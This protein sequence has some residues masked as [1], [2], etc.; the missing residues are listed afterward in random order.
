[1]NSFCIYLHD[2][3]SAVEFERKILWL[4]SR[5]N[6]ISHSD[7][8]DIVYQGKSIKNSCHITVDDGWRSTYE[9]VMPIMKK[10]N[11]PFSMFVSP[12]IINE[13]INYWYYNLKLC[14][15]NSLYDELIKRKY[16]TRDVVKFPLDL[17]LK[18]IKIDNI[19]ALISD[20]L[21]NNNIKPERGF[22]N[23]KE[24]VEMSQSSLIEI[25]AHTLTHPILSMESD[26]RSEYEIIESISLLENSIEKSVYSFAY[27][28]GLSRLDFS[29]REKQFLKKTKIKLAYSV[30]PGFVTNNS[31]PFSIPRI[32]NLKRLAFGSLG[33]LLPSLSSQEK[34]RKKLREIR[35]K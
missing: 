17:A 1:M 21:K 2:E 3:I 30:N 23:L 14:P 34:I 27:P 5:Y 19:I 10:Y 22:I 31:D 35:L 15:V 18:E 33:T 24:L 20:V 8:S 12:L 29:E 11:I 28:N 13:E 4:K 32:G 16:Y 9:I 26:E 7:I 6:F 25:G